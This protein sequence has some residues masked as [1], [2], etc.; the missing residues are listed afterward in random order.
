MSAPRGV[1]F[2][3]TP[4]LRDVPEGNHFPTAPQLAALLD[5]AGFRVAAEIGS[6]A[7]PGS[8]ASWQERIDRVMR[9]CPSTTPGTRLELA[10]AQ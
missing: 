9:T 7:L 6:A 2:G 5:A 3:A 8:P 4:D 1:P 10:Q